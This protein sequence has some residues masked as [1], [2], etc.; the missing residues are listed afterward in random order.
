V[1]LGRRYLDKVHLF[2][3][4]SRKW[5]GFN[6]R[7]DSILE[8]HGTQL[9]TLG[10]SSKSTSCPQEQ[11]YVAVTRSPVE[12]KKVAMLSPGE[13]K[14]QPMHPEVVQQLAHV[15]LTELLA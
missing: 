2:R 1:I 10:N 9:N 14:K 6:E 3:N 11:S 12:A 15:L 7:I 8:S 13:Q 5:L 4:V